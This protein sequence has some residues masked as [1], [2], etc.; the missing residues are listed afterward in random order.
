MKKYY[1]NGKEG[2]CDDERRRD[3]AGCKHFNGRGG[4]EREVEEVEEVEEDEEVC[5]DIVEVVRCKDCKHWKHEE[6][7]DFVC[8]KHFGYRLST[9]FCSDG[10]RSATNGLL[11]TGER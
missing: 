5:A 6:D 8:T 10:E 1:C 4:E 11:Q 9:D 7:V 3:C 2:F